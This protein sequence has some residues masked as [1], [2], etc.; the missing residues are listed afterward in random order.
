MTIM[1]RNE[2][3]LGASLLWAACSTGGGERSITLNI[4]GAA[5]ATAYFDRYQNNRPYHVDSVKLDASGQGRINT[6]YMPLDFYRIAVGNEQLVVVLDS[7]EDLRVEASMGSL[8][9]PKKV[10]GSKHTDLLVRFQREAQGYDAKVQG[11]RTA[12]ATDPT[13]AANLDELNL[14]NTMFYESC[15]RMVQENSGSPVAISMLGR[16]NLM[17]EFELFKQV[18]DSLRKTMPGSGFFTLFRDQVDRYEQEQLMIKL[19]EEEAKRLSNLLPIGSEAPEI[20]QQT[21][22]GGTLAL[23]SLRGKYVLIDFWASWCRPCRI[24]NPNV[25]RVYERFKSKGFEILGVSLD[26]DH[27]AWV[28]A[29]R[30]DGLP[31]KHV[32]DLGFWNNAAAQQYGVGSIPYTVLVDREGRILEKGLR[33]EQLEARLAELLK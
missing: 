9:N 17:Q 30:A 15:K 20:M 31:W 19:Q 7:A 8:G 11:L 23:S 3:L 24:E 2:L 28:D 33:G 16:M 18:R 27:G 5:G 14:T 1:Q 26:R 6:T 32:S 21:P 13:N 25:K 12:L 29:I 10:E 22:E 4:N